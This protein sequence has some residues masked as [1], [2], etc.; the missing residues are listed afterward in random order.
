MSVELHEALADIA[1]I[2]HQMARTEVF[3][4]YRALPVA[5]SGAAALAAG[6]IQ[7]AFVADPMQRLSAYLTLWIGAA[8]LSA[9]GAAAGM[10]DRRRR[11]ASAWSREVTIHAVEQ[12]VPS[13]IAG[14]LLTAVL[15]ITAPELSWLLPGLWQV[16]FALGIFA[17]S[18]LLPAPVRFV[19]A[20]Y[21]VTG[22]AC[23]AMARGDA[24]LSPWAMALP[25]GIG[26][27][28]ASFVLYSTLE[29]TPE[30]AR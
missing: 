25:F 4:G 10:V 2:R 14:G 16:L 1:Q 20:W 17:S 6:L 5:F 26:Q 15:V 19:A 23:L 12:F 30:V 29:R 9:A 7:A 11:S 28:L 3:R 21:L 27:F 13:I 22:I 24:A 18:R 8:L